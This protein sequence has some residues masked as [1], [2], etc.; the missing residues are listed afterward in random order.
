MPRQPMDMSLF[1][2]LV[3]EIDGLPMKPPNHIGFGLFGDGLVDPFVVERME[4]ARHRIPNSHLVVNTN[5]AAFNV[6]RHSIL[7]DLADLVTLHCES[8]DPE[9]YDHL[10]QPLRARNVFPRYRQLLDAFPGKVHVS[11]PVSRMNLQQLAEIRDQFMEWG[12]LDVHFDP[13]ASRCDPDITVFKRLALSPS[14]I[15]CGPDVLDNLIID[16]DGQILICC[17]DF[18]REEPIGSLTEEPL[19]QLLTN[20]QRRLVRRR[21][22]NG[23][24]SEMATCSRC[25]GDLRSEN[26]PFDVELVANT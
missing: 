8:L 21:F 18:V 15:R 25:F 12:A 14:P 2:K 13:L 19:L 20:Q 5:G 10:M 7:N 3:N 24:H 4:Y 6:K 22:A 23:D 17:Q 16:C 1:K 11:V 9:T 26:F